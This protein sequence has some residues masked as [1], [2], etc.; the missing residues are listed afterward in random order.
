MLWKHCRFP[1]RTHR[2]SLLLAQLY[3]KEKL[4]A[5]RGKKPINYVQTYHYGKLDSDRMD[6]IKGKFLPS[7]PH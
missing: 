2:I 3:R 1:L 6:R 7:L 4:Q 5:K